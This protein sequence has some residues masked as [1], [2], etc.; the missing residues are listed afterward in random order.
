MSVKKL[1]EYADEIIIID[2]GSQDKTKNV[3]NLYTDK[4]FDFEWC[5]DFS[6]A[7]NY[8]FSKATCEYVIAIQK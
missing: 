3:A 5:D 7:R 1:N 4:L 2:T 8:S 6:K